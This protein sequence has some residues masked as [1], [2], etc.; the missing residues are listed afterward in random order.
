MRGVVAAVLALALAACTL[1]QPPFSPTLKRQAAVAGVPYFAQDDHQ[2][3][4]AALAMA[5]SWAG[6]PETPERL[7]SLVYTPGRDGS[8]GADMVTAA[9]RAG[10]LAVAI[11]SEE[12]LLGELDAG[13]PV[14]VLLNLGLDLLPLWHYAVVVGYDL[15]QGE[16]SLQSGLDPGSRMQ[17]TPFRGT[18]ERGGHWGMV[19]LPPDMLP[20][21]APELAVARAAA[22]LERAG[23]VAEAATTYRAMQRRW[24]TSVVARIGLGNALA[25]LGDRDGAA[26]MFAQAL[27]LDPQSN[28]A[29]VNLAELRRQGADA[30]DTDGHR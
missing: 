3:G 11:D 21:T 12:G 14:V 17:F 22:G 24:P 26:E 10:R 23:R 13:H 6:R 19:V 30:G 25:T 28:A 18:W 27:A 7:Q 15:E 5:L 8:L 9:R 29:A 1:P 2:C 16:I 4:P 20:E